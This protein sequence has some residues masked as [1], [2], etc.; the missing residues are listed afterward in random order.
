LEDPWDRAYLVGPDGQRDTFA[1]PILWLL[2]A[3]T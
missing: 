2:D 3:T 1:S